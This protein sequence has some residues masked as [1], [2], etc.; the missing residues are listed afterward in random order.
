MGARFISVSEL[1]HETLELLRLLRRLPAVYRAVSSVNATTAERV[2]TRRC[3]LK[4][5]LVLLRVFK[6]E[7]TH[8]LISVRTD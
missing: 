3:E 4:L 6:A 8:S 7:V 2:V 5:T 1:K